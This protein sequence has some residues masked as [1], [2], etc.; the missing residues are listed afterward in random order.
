MADLKKEYD[1]N[2]K[3][4]ELKYKDAITQL[5]D[6]MIYS[7]NLLPVLDEYARMVANAREVVDSRRRTILGNIELNSSVIRGL[8]AQIKNIITRLTTL[9]EKSEASV[10][11]A[12]ETGS[13]GDVITAQGVYQQLMLALEA[14]GAQITSYQA[15]VSDSRRIVDELGAI[16]QNILPVDESNLMYVVDVDKENVIKMTQDPVVIIFLLV[17]IGL[18]VYYFQSFSAPVYY[19]PMYTPYQITR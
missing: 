1:A 19:I 15:A 10:A 3:T 16:L 9:Y 2:K 18:A 11:K 13:P 17:M 4:V 14:S 5:G 12:V 6:I 7:G 8:G